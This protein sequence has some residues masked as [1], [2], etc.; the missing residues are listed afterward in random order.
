VD[1]DPQLVISGVL[2][3][4]R[5]WETP[6]RTMGGRWI[7]WN[8]AWAA[9]AALPMRLFNRVTVLRRLD[10]S[11]ASGLAER[12]IT[13]FG[14]HPGEG[15]YL[16]N[17]P[18]AT[19]DLEPY[20]FTR[21]WTLPFMVRKSEGTARDRSDVDI[22]EVRSKGDFEQ[23]VHALIEGFTIPVPM[24]HPITPIMDERVVM[25]GGMRCWVAIADGLP[26]GTSVAYLADGVVGVY[27]VS[28]V[29]A[30]RRQGLGETLTWRAALTDPGAPSTLQ[31]SE[32]GRPLYEQM[33]YV[34]ALDCATWVKPVR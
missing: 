33:G 32:L 22:R 31:A 6:A 24:S 2:N 29:P 7:R 8:D 13:F 3:M 14:P 28:V 17:D 23:F 19:L 26:V 5:M 20:G 4:A 15:E 21:W 11:A 1:V 27:L 10:P 30:M 18:W 25:D 9:D 16:V 12:V 34:R